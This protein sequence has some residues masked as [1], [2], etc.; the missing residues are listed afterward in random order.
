MFGRS[1]AGIAVSKPRRRHGRLSVVSFSC[2][3]VEISA[4]GRSLIQSSPTE[5]GES[6]NDIE[7]S[8]MRSVRLSRNVDHDN[9]SIYI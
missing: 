5:Y 8:T 1:D 3:Q 6:E 2:C 9:M 4:W 7:R